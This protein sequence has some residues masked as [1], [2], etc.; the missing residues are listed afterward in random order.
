MISELI[1]V[2]KL[3]SVVVA[4]LRGHTET[5]VW[6]HCWRQ[7]KVDLHTFRRQEK[8]FQFV[9][10]HERATNV[11]ILHVLIMYLNNVLSCCT[12]TGFPLSQKS[13]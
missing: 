3:E 8:C 10:I 12:L 4:S 13:L 5:A 2:C 1:A 11:C 7:K 6:R 9:I